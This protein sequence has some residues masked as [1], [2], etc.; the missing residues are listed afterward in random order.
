MPWGTD[1]LYMYQSTEL[2]RKRAK[3]AKLLQT[4]T[5]CP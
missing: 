5:F 3:Q 4:I 2:E 1:W